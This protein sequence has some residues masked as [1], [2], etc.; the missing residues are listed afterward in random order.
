MFTAAPVYT[1]ATYFALGT[2]N[3]VWDEAPEEFYVCCCYATHF[4]KVYS[5]LFKV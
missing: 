1:Y 4:F 2:L 3:I 5:H